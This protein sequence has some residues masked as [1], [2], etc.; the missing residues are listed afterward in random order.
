[1]SPYITR[2]DG[3]KE[4]F[5]ADMINKSIERAAFGLTDPISKVMQVATDTRLTVYDGISTEQMD[6]ATIIAA[7]QNIKDDLGYDTIAT[8]LFLKTIYKKVLGPY[9]NDPHTLDIKHKEY[10]NRYIEE[11]IA[12]GRLDVRMREKFDLPMLAAALDLKRDGLFQYTGISTVAELYLL[13][14]KNQDHVET[15]QIFFMRVAMG[16]SYNEANPTDAAIRFYDKMSRM[17]YIAGSS[18]NLGAG[19]TRP[20]LAN[21][22]LMEV[23]DDMAHISKSVSDVM[24]LSKGSGGMGVS[25]TKLRASGSPLKSTNG[26]SSGPTP[27]AKIMDT[28]IRAIMRAGKRRG[29]LCFY[30][31]TWHYDFPDFLEWKHNAGDDYMRMRTANTAAFISDEFMKRVGTGEDWYMFDPAETPDLNEMYGKVF[32]KRYMEYVQMAEEGKLY[33]FKKVPAKELYRQMLVAL[34]TTSHPWQVWKDPINLRAMNNNTGTIHMSNLCT[35]ICLPQD[36]DNIAVCNLASLNLAAH[37]INKEIQW[38]KLEETVRSAIRQLDNLIDINLL[39]IAEARKSD[40]ENRAVGLG[41]MGLADVFEKIGIAYESEA[42]YNFT[43]RIFEFVSYMAIDESANLA[44]ERGSY[45][46]FEG[47]RWSKGQVP[48][49]TLEILEDRRGVPLAVD[50]VSHHK[51]L[52]WDILREKVKKGMRNA[53][54]MAV[55]PNA[56]IGLV[57]GT[58]PGIDGRFAQVFSRN[59]LS[60]KYLDLNHNLVKDLNNLGIWDEVKEQIIA[61]Q[62]DLT[63][64]DKIPQHIK[65]IYKTSFT[66]SPYAYVEVAARAQKWTDQALSR[67]IYLDSR[68]VDVMMDL[69]STAWKKG[70][71][72]TYYLHMKPRHT[73][74]QSTVAVNKAQKMGRKGFGAVAGLSSVTEPIKEEPVPIIEHI[75]EEVAPITIPVESG[76]VVRVEPV[77]MIEMTAQIQKPAPS[78]GYTIHMPEDPADANACISCQ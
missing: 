49:D 5:N 3:T 21:C 14:N 45:K 36:K 24:M 16:L 66:T 29:A 27:F 48:I 38:Q 69:Y 75:V 57:A 56:T 54:L 52:N 65:D 42:A 25:L 9:D 33:M 22:F 7:V 44:Q 23:H 19:T 73:A 4:E 1:M 53:T 67:N 12:E 77:E 62:G 46:N 40:S 78:G 13:T 8:R 64:I 20:A 51:G 72:S 68:D 74:E 70:L 35:E 50:K 31:E 59:T 10:F 47:S 55:A 2:R 32:S 37:I 26:V 76:I 6:Q 28:A 17:E 61:H 34:Q 43:D 58:V 18:V 15:P 60:G 63:N 71:K 30:M 39:P 41:V 11:G